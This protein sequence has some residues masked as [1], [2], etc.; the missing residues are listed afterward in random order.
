[1]ESWLEKNAIEMY[2]SYN[3]VKDSLEPLKIKFIN[4]WL[5]LQKMCILIN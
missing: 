4:I 5:Q 2:S 1:M 3:E